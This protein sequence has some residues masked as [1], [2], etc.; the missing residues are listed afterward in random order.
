MTEK[1]PDKSSVGYGRPPVHSRF[2]SGQSGNP[3]GRRRGAKNMNSIVREALT[4]KVTIREGDKIYKVTQFEA[5]MRNLA[6]NAMKGDLKAIKTILV[7][8]E[9]IDIWQ[10][11]KIPTELVVRFV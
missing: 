9:H 6:I 11:E 10:E 3:S 8:M 2:K 5:I 7:L 4:K 1:K